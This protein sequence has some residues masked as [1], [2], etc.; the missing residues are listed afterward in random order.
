M[1]FEIGK[2][3]NDESFVLVVGGF[4][5]RFRRSEIDSIEDIGR[6]V[7]LD[8][9][10]AIAKLIPRRVKLGAMTA[11]TAEVSD[12]ALSCLN[13]DILRFQVV[14]DQWMLFL[15]V[16]GVAVVESYSNLLQPA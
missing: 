10:V 14:M 8:L 13:Q 6:R 4:K 12:F 11:G 16:S 2:Q 9:G 3:R 7:L 15:L 1:S 5:A